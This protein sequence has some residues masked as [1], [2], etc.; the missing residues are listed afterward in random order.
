MILRWTKP[1][2]DDLS[3]ICDYTEERFGVKQAGRTAVAIYDSVDSL[4]HMPRRGR[5]G[6]KRGTLELA[7]SGLPFVIIYNVGNE[8]VEIVR[9]LHGARQWP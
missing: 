2:A 9:I 7:V 1:A 4:Q 8:A 6:R 3:L 5:S